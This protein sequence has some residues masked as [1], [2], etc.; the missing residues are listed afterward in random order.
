MEDDLDFDCSDVSYKAILCG[1]RSS[2]TTCGNRRKMS[3]WDQSESSTRSH[4]SLLTTMEKFVQTVD[5]MNETI[6]VPCRL[7]DAKFDS[8]SQISTPANTTSVHSH[9]VDPKTRLLTNLN[10]VDLFQF[11]TILN[12]VK[13]DLMW[14]NKS[15]QA[16]LPQPSSINGIM[17]SSSNH[18]VASSSLSSSGNSSTLSS[19]ASSVLSSNNHSGGSSS[20]G[21]IIKGHVR[22]P[23]TVST[24]SSASASDTEFSE[25]NEDSGL[26]GEEEYSQHLADAF[27][28]HLTGLQQCLKDLTLAADYVTNRYNNDLGSI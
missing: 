20:N 17:T 28:H 6:L 27:H 14:G 13:S 15:Q 3:R 25:L 23:S 1:T 24:T 18:S 5:D 9:V 19:S 22:R 16:P 11:Y 7:M 12:S 4:G 21:D 10:G 2:S 8:S 26:E